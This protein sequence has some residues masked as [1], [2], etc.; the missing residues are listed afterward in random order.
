V[1]LDFYLETAYINLLTQNMHLDD[2]VKRWILYLCLEWRWLQE[3]TTKWWWTKN[4]QNISV[5]V[6]RNR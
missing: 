2:C 3:E 1:V 6:M 4:I 5:M